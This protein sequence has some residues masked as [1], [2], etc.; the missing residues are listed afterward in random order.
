MQVDPKNLIQLIFIKLSSRRIWK[1]T[2]LGIGMV[3]IAAL[4]RLLLLHLGFLLSEAF[5]LSLKSL[6]VP[7]VLSGLGAIALFINLAIKW[8]SQDWRAAKDHLRKHLLESQIPAAGALAIFFLYNLVYVVPHQLRVV[9]VKAP[10]VSFH[11]PPAPEPPPL[12][13]PAPLGPAV[14]FPALVQVGTPSWTLS[15]RPV[16]TIVELQYGNAGPATANQLRA[17]ANAI[18]GFDPP[19]E[20]EDRE[21]SKLVKGIPGKLKPAVDMYAGNK[22]FIQNFFPELVGK[23]M[24]DLVNGREWLLVVGAITYT[25][26][27]GPHRKG[28]CYSYIPMAET[29]AIPLGEN[30]LLQHWGVCQPNSLKIWEQGAST[31]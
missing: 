4:A 3:A 18:F 2:T 13:Q 22:S 8:C 5:G 26:P 14:R 21:F 1:W 23:K 31:R 19:A 29:H 7:F 25:D 11:I 9:S 24:E 6:R 20:T 12:R 15:Q 16:D 17:G 30:P 10:E 28:L 27:T